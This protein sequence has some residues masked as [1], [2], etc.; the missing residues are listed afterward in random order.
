MY[1]VYMNT[2]QYTIRNVPS[3]VTRV[4]KK[5]A[6]RSNKSFNQVVVDALVEQT[7][8]G[9]GSGSDKAGWL[10][11]KHQLDAGF[12]EAIRRQSEIDEK[13]WQ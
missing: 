13:L 10:F 1:T 3:D 6:Q 12:D 4:L 11:G 2:Q 9:A 7:L 8:H 5:R